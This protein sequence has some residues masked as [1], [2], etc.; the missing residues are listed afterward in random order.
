VKGQETGKRALEI[1]AAGAHNVLLSGPPGSGKTMLARRLPGILPPLTLEEALDATRVHSVAGHLAS[2]GAL[3]TKRPFRAPHHTVSDAGLVGGGVPLR[4]GEV[5]L[6]HHGVLFLDEL[7]EFRRNVLEVLRQPLEDGVVH[8]SRARGAERFP[9]RF[10]LIGAMNPCKCGYHGDGSN[11][12]LCDPSEVAR[13]VSRISGPLLDRLDLHVEVPAVSFDSL[14]DD[15]R[16]ES[17]EV[18]RARVALA[19]SAQQARFRSYPAV[20]ANGQM[21][22]AMLRTLAHPTL[23]VARVLHRSVDLHGL[24]ARAY[25]RVLKVARTLADLAGAEKVAR[26]HIAEALSYRLNFGLV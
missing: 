9:A 20:F 18:V 24:S 11:R 25:H 3:L 1:A 6:A 19:R 21:D 7:A 14:A 12:C 8:L 17:S 16:G 5:S 10:L 2:G 26:P 22:A 23:P 4:P 15:T 13:Y